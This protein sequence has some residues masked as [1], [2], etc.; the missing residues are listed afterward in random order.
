MSY[1]EETTTVFG[2][3]ELELEL[4]WCEK[5]ILLPGWR[6][7]AGTKGGEKNTVPLEAGVSFIGTTLNPKL[8]Q[9][10]SCGPLSTSKGID[11]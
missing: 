4:K 2:R 3:L 6:L 11:P 1:A 8:R 7:E 9:W 5:K 10:R